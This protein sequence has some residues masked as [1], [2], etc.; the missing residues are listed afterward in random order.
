MQ[1]PRLY[2]QVPFS[3]QPEPAQAL[4]AVPP[5]T[6]TATSREPRPPVTCSFHT[7][8]S[9]GMSC[10]PP[11]VFSIAAPAVPVLFRTGTM[12]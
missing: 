10:G 5:S 6:T 2:R 1:P 4:G 3:G 11:E 12:L 8:R 9:R 7:P